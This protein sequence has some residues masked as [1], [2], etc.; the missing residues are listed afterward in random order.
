MLPRGLSSQPSV[1]NSNLIAVR[2]AALW[3]VSWILD[4]EI[5][6]EQ[7]DHRRGLLHLPRW[8]EILGKRTVYRSLCKQGCYAADTEKPTALHSNHTKWALLRNMLS[9]QDKIRLNE[10]DKELV[11]RKRDAQGRIR[12]T[13][14]RDALKSTQSYTKEF[15]RALAAAWEGQC[16]T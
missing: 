10:R 7:P 5:V 3:E 11:T 14:K 13:G 4:Q 15:G 12:T 16:A 2:S 9:E 6:L 1:V 8:Q